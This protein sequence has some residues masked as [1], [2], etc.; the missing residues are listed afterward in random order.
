M[1]VLKAK[2]CTATADGPTKIELVWHKHVPGVF[3]APPGYVVAKHTP[4]YDTVLFWHPDHNKALAYA[5]R[6]YKRLERE[7]N[8]DNRPR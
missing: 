8:E 1:T 7:A 2:F 4:D 6:T 5:T 3:D